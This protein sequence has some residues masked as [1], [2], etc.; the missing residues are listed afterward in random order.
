[1]H[2]SQRG[3]ALMPYRTASPAQRLREFV[4]KHN[5]W[6]LNIAGSRASEEPGVGDFVAGVLKAAWS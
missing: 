1:M 6:V 5:I 4:E 3:Y 2:L